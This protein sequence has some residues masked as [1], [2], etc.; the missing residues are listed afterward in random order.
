MVESVPRENRHRW[1]PKAAAQASA[2]HWT[3]S[4]PGLSSRLAAAAAR[5]PTAMVRAWRRSPARCL[6]L[7]SNPWLGRARAMR[8]CNGPGR[9]APAAPRAGTGRPGRSAGGEAVVGSGGMV[10]PAAFEPTPVLDAWDETPQF[11]AVRLRLAPALAAAHVLPGQVVKLR[12]AAGEGYFAL[13]SGPEAEPIA[14]L[15]VKRGGKV[16]DLAAA[17]TAGSSLETSAPF[18]KGFPVREGVGRHVLL[19]AAGSGIAPI[20]ALVQHVLAR[21]Q[22]FEQVTLFY[23]Q[24]RGGDFAYAGEHVAWERGGVRVVLCPSREGDAWNGVRGRV[25]E[26]ARSLAFGGSPPGESVAFVCGMHAMVSDVRATLA[27][28]GVPPERIHVNF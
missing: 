16:A 7:A 2:T 8:W 1:A 14:D 27:R 17:A 19:F 22:D 25:Q 3:Q 4:R 6:S 24:Q 12:T 20:R 9:S 10:V 18:G 15:L 23:G 28:A 26:V 11:R 5:I 21:R 13:A